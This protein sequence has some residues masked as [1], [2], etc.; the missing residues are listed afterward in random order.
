[1]TP[2]PQG[3][4]AHYYYD[5]NGTMVKSVIDDIVTYY[6]SSAYQV[7][8][9]GSHTN[10]RKYYS[11]GSTAVAM[12]ENNGVI[13]LLQDQVNSTTITADANGILLSETRYSAFG[14]VRYANG[15][16]VTDKL[17]T[18]QQQET[19]IG[20]DYYVA[21][22]YD[23]EIAHFVQPDMMVSNI[24]RLQGFDLYSY[25]NNNPIKLIDPSGHASCNFLFG[26]S[27]RSTLD[28]LLGVVYQVVN[29]LA[30]NLPNKLIGTS[31]QNTMS[32][33]FQSGLTVGRQAS[34]LIGTAA[35]AN[36]IKN[37]A[38]GLGALAATAAGGGACA[39]LSG[40][41]CVVPA[42]AAL[43]GEGTLA[44]V[45]AGES[46]LGAA[47]VLSNSGNSVQTPSYTPNNFRANLKNTKSIPSDI[48]VNDAQA[49][50][51]LPQALKGKFDPL[52][53]DINDPKWGAWVKA[54]EHQSWSRAYNDE[55]VT[56]FDQMGENI[57]INDVELKASA[58]AN[59]YG[60]TWP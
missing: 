25:V 24:G 52:G 28:Y 10:T 34:N 6:A 43:A 55:W 9:D 14:E 5:G 8:T 4:K 36:G 27:G 56:W 48:N 45:G 33:H 29:D 49:H 7:K 3:G 15:T 38:I 19:E 57:T 31:W 53:I 60:F 26:C 11:F 54:G 35:T 16:T 42:G 51:V 22:F 2:T 41:T 20:L 18:G 50:H 39:A 40:G 23:P 47:I 59:I 58:L 21:R 17:Y 12:R 1:M 13:W 30:F 44:L 46:A 32:F 37:T